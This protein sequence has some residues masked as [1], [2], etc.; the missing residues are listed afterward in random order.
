M[1]KVRKLILKVERSVNIL[2]IIV[3]G[4]AKAVPSQKLTLFGRGLD[5]EKRGNLWLKMMSP[6]KLKRNVPSVILL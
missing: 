5:V 1:T 3:C 4:F 2:Y 6:W